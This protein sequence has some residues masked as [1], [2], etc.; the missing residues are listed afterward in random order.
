MRDRFSCIGSIVVQRSKRHTTPL[1]QRNIRNLASL[2]VPDGLN[3]QQ[4][5]RSTILSYKPGFTWGT[6]N[7]IDVKRWDFNLIK[8]WPRCS[9]RPKQS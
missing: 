7:R 1:N 2:A 3:E 4:S 6:S 9:Y 5:T 8:E